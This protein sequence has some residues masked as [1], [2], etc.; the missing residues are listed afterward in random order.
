MGLDSTDSLAIL[1]A[2]APQ[3]GWESDLALF[4]SYSV[5]LVAVAAIIEALAGEGGDHERM[6]KASFARACERMRDRFRVVCQ[7][8]RVAVPSSGASTLVIADRWIREV[9]H[10]ANEQSWHAKLALVRYRSMD[11]PDNEAE[12]RLW[13]GSRNLTRDTSWDSALVAL[14]TFSDPANSIDKSVARAGAVLAD[15]AALEGWPPGKVRD[16]LDRLHWIWPEDFQEVVSFAMWPDAQPTT[17][18]PNPPRGLS[19]IVAVSPF[20]N[21]SVANKLSGWGQAVNRQLLTTHSTLSEL[22]AQKAEP[23][24]G[25]SSLH[26]LDVPAGAED[27]DTDQDETGDDQMAE[28][29]RGLHA[30]LLWARSTTGD[31]LWLGSANLTERA[32]N[33]RNT[34][35]VVHARVVPRVGDGLLDGLVNGLATEV[36]HNTL[37]TDQPVKDPAEQSLDHLRNRIAACWHARL[38]RAEETGNLRCDTQVAP[39]RITDNAELSVRLLGQT[40]WKPWRPKLTAVELPA[41]SLHCQTEL[42]ELELRSTENSDLAVSWVARAVMDPPLDITRDRAVLARLM[43]PRALLVWLRTLLGEITGEVDDDTWPER[44]NGQVRRPKGSSRNGCAVAWSSPTLENVLRAWMRNPKAVL[45][46]DRAL[47]TWAREIR[48]GV[49]VDADP[50][51][52]KALQELDHFEAAWKV[53]REGLHLGGTAS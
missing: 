34:E 9:R 25:F 8:G 13:I 33:G 6:R 31:E 40:G 22:A 19:H 27:A 38:E 11:A 43:G 3:P 37:T 2:L 32:W 7:A 29:H 14:G 48:A 15:K 42:L 17:G 46:V 47:D 44:T 5:D 21:G 16:E 26:Q 53:I 24:T 41:T 52:R 51:D 10:D 35:A 39:L 28:V 50:E 23:L 36:P 1:D 20:V 45:E 4:S 18:F 12:W 49:A 30:K